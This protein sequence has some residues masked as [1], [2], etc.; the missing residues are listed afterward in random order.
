MRLG[1]II[2]KNINKSNPA[3]YEKEEGNFLCVM[4]NI[5]K[6]PT[7]NIFNS[8]KTNISTKI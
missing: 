2:L 4:K 7:T 5:Y 8:E 3:M 1:P 6:N